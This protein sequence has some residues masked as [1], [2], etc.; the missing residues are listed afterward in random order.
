MSKQRLSDDDEG[1]VHP[2]WTTDGVIF[3]DARC[4]QE[5]ANSQGSSNQNAQT[6][7]RSDD[8]VMRNFFLLSL[9][10]CMWRA[11]F[12]VISSWFFMRTIE[13]YKNHY[14]HNDIYICIK[15]KYIQ[16]FKESFLSWD[17]TCIW[18]SWM[19]KWEPKMA[20]IKYN[21]FCGEND[22]PPHLRSKYE[23]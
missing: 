14:K 18:F 5:T 16:E 15:Q 6:H 1:K 20:S 12:L 13:M 2:Q 10:Y 17:A 22:T 8:F 9:T 21:R 23:T 4:S 19:S 7:G 11:W 3:N